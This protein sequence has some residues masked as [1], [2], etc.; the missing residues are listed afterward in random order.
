MI[1][2]LQQLLDTVNAYLWGFPMIIAL[3]GT[4]IFL[5]IKL[6]GLQFTRLLFALNAAFVKR[7]EH[8]AKV[9]G[10]ISN[11]QA[12]MTALAATVGT[13][14]I[15]GVATAIYFGG[16]GALFW[17]WITG[18]I[19]MVLKYSESLLAVKYRIQDERGE[20]C[21][22]PMYYLEKALK[23][24]WLGV[25]F[26]VATAIAAFGI[27]NMV[28]AHAIAHTIQEAFGIVPAVTGIV[29]A[30]LTMLVIIGG[31]K[32]IAKV[33][34]FL[35]PF[36]IVI[37]ITG[38]VTVIAVNLHKVPGVLMM[39][40]Q[41]AFTGQAA[42]GSIIGLAVI[43][44]MRY[45]F[46]RGVFSNESG[47]GSAPIAAAAARCSH[48]VSQALVSMTQTFIDTLIVCSLTGLSIL[49]TDV[50]TTG[51]S[52]EIM[53]AQA[54]NSIFGE[55]MG[56]RIIAAAIGLF[57][58]STIIGWYYYGEKGIEYLFGVNV[59]IPY[60]LCWSC[61]VILGALSGLKNIWNFADFFNGMM[62]LPNLLA[63]ILLS[64]IIQ[65]ETI[66]YFKN[67]NRS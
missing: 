37:Y 1:A 62:I 38:C 49:V 30:V 44:T 17:M 24:K 63:L 8:G 57:A 25:F 20:Y 11:F 61:M 40:M 34:S 33:T 65:S 60:K 13:G 47:M 50:H 53:T 18:L 15:I 64:G 35:V 46:A 58:F 31:I 22:G 6:K 54:F 41:A 21:G 55:P 9:R 42:R 29:C 14:N 2:G 4:G 66:D 52:A 27:G 43:Y 26:A 56:A 5:T 36:M 45:G 7:S 28:Q 51:V 48:P 3:V 16:P 32:S 39:V 10:T 59:I 67:I 23:L 12:L 19:G